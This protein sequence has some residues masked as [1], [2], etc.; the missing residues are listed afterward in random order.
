MH[1]SEFDPEKTNAMGEIVP[2][3][4]IDHY[5]IVEN[6]GSGPMRALIIEIKDA[7]GAAA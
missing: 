2:G 1:N 3:L 6:I 7:Q 5:T 4:V